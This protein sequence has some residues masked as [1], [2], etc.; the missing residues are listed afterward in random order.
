MDIKQLARPGYHG[1]QFNTDVSVTLE[2]DLLR[3]DLTINA[4]AENSAGKIIDPFKGKQ[5]IKDRILRH[6]SPAFTEDPV[7]VLR[8]AKFMAR[9]AHLGFTVD[10]STSE[11]VRSMVES[12]EVDNLVAERV[13]QEFHAALLSTSP[14]AFFRTL[15]QTGALK[16]IMPEIDA[17]LLDTPALDALAYS[18]TLSDKA[19]VRFAALCS[20]FTEDQASTVTKL[21]K[22]LRLP[23]GI[24]ELG[25]LGARYSQQAHRA[26]SLDA[27]ELH[28][29]LRALDVTRRPDRFSEFL[30]AA[31]AHANAE[32]NSDEQYPQGTHL[33]LCAKAI[34]SINAAEIAKSHPNKT[35]ISTAIRQAEIS[36]IESILSG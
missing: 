2:D 4:I 17:L 31:S 30:L 29:L 9:F 27:Q 36:A 32:T 8:I 16:R 20:N 6:V 3:R 11:L 15:K 19:S 5:A 25:L 34:T 26:L 21:S 18:C 33:K 1:F 24:A 7:R 35:T 13:W 14:E 22:R 28:K 10:H 23:S 12:G